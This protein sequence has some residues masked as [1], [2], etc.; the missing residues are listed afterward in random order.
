MKAVKLFAVAIVT[1]ASLSLMAQQVGASAQ[2]SGSASAAG[3]NANDSAN[4]A[5]NL[6]AQ[7]RPVSGELVRALDSKSARVGESV[8]LKTTEE[9]RTAG[10]MVIP[11]GSRLQG[12]VTEV[13]AH[14]KEHENSQIGIEFDHV[15][16]K[17]GQSI[18]IHSVIESVLESESA[19][20]AEAN[21]RQNAA[22]AFN[23]PGPNG[24][25]YGG[26]DMSGTATSGSNVAGTGLVGDAVFNANAAGEALHPS[27]AA[28]ST[29]IA[30][31]M[32]SGDATGSASGVLS[33]AKKNVHLDYGTRMVVGIAAA[34][35]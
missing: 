4:G 24:P 25:A 11:K 22:D 7:M 33:A 9:A 35:N 17:D 34:G 6:S 18:A 3:A 16:L 21:A 32:L 2:Q 1:L 12:H 10:G 23:G 29:G 13:Q 30:G 8:E 26:K 20:A 5:A 28:S 15:V 27:T 14:K 19:I 31:V